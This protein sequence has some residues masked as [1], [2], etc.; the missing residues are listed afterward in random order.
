MYALLASGRLGNTT[1]QFLSLD[2]WEASDDAARYEMWGVRT[3]TPGGPCRLY[4][5]RDE[6]RQTAQSPLFAP[7]AI[8]ISM[9]VDAVARV[10]LWADIFDSEYGL[11]VYGIEHPP[12]GGSWRA[13]MP[14]QGREWRGI[15]ARMLLRRH[16][17]A[18]SLADIDELREMYP[19]HVHEISALSRCLGIYPGRNYVS[20]EVRTST[21][22]YERWL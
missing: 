19:G 21:G 14:S 2:E 8:N 12:R 11:I 9:M 15:E 18:S 22:E 4:C 20:W 5:P 6:V 3:L 10:T 17:N 13:L 1:R 7:H 16:L